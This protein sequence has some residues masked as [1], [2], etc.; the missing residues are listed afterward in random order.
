MDTKK[1]EI[2]V[3]QAVVL[4]TLEDTIIDLLKNEQK[5]LTQRNGHLAI[6]YLNIL[7]DKIQSA[8]T[9]SHVTDETITVLTKECLHNATLVSSILK[10]YKPP[11]VNDSQSKK[12]TIEIKF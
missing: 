7:K 2:N 6:R 11:I 8:L 12:L 9:E 3:E 5:L 4:V 1:T 10:S